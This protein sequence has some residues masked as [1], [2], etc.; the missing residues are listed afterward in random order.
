MDKILAFA[1][2]EWAEWNLGDAPFLVVKGESY[3]H[4]LWIAPVLYY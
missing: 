1:S 3:F 2:R 4:L